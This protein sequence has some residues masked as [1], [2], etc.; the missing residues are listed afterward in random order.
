MTG[1][2]PTHVASKCP[3]ESMFDDGKTCKS[4]AVYKNVAASPVEASPVEA[5]RA[6][7]L[8]TKAHQK[9]LSKIPV[10]EQ[11]TASIALD[12]NG[13][14]AYL[15]RPNI[16]LIPLKLLTDVVLD[17]GPS[18]PPPII[19]NT[20]KD[21]TRDSIDEVRRA[22]Q[23]GNLDLYRKVYA[24]SQNYRCVEHGHSYNGIGNL[25]NHHYRSYDHI[26]E[27]EDMPTEKLQAT[28]RVQREV[29]AWLAEHMARE[30]VLNEDGRIL[31]V[32]YWVDGSPDT[33]PVAHSAVNPE[34]HIHAVH[35]NIVGHASHGDP[36]THGFQGQIHGPTFVQPLAGSGQHTYHP[37]G[38]SSDTGPV[39]HSAVRPEA[40]IHGAHGVPG[41]PG[42]PEI[43][44]LI[45]IH[46]V[47]GSY[48]VL[49]PHGAPRPPGGHT[50]PGGHATPGSQGHSSARHS[51]PENL[52]IRSDSNR[53]GHGR[54][55]RSSNAI[56]RRELAY[57]GPSGGSSHGP[58]HT[59]P[60]AWP[61]HAGQP[62][63]SS[64]ASHEPR[65]AGEGSHH[66]HT[67]K[68]RPSGVGGGSGN[69]TGPGTVPKPGARP[70]ELK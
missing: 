7:I 27:I 12:L 30:I 42:V 29:N 1:V 39:A 34:G 24:P 25:R 31:E 3:F 41:I 26:K 60:P 2:Y 4:S 23:T 50:I 14:I 5:L 67:G 56:P 22:F 53:D 10:T 33:G 63:G 17:R 35:G 8:A 54:W 6:H 21:S 57:A 61:V 18:N 28:R 47:P 43:H 13:Y 52:P 58:P 59:V 32:K 70:W 44:G 37:G 36:A 38:G 62:S 69:Q 20:P 51:Y 55:D 45:G 68:E 49:V 66:G 9:R 64:H 16:P 19:A 40:L 65:P 46:G 48:G 15:G 11:I